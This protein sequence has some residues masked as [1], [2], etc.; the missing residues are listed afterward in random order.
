MLKISHCGNATEMT[1]WD[2]LDSLR[3]RLYCFWY[4]LARLKR[5]FWVVWHD[6]DCDYDG[7]LAFMEV[8]LRGM[9]R[10]HR[11]GEV[12]CVGWERIARQLQ[13]CRVLCARL[14]AD[15]YFCN[16]GYDHEGWSG[17]SDKKQARIAR[18]SHVMAIQDQRHLG[19]ILGKHLMRWW[20]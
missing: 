20:I 19:Q 10:L 9:E 18:H 14:R 4:S 6:D 11:E 17:M 3:F 16:A 2:R 5:Y 12:Q 8:K 15:D 13:I 7:L 1:V